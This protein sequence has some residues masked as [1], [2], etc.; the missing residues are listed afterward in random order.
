M[1]LAHA[2]EESRFGL[3]GSAGVFFPTSSV[4]RDKFGSS[5]T[6][7]GISPS[8]ESLPS[9][10]RIFTDI[11]VL[12]ANRSGNR[13]LVIPATIGF[14]KTFGKPADVSR[15]YARVGVGIAYFDYSISHEGRRRSDRNFGAAADAE[16]GVLVG[17]RLRLSARYYFL[18]E[19]DGFNFNGLELA[20]KYTLFRF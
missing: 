3:G 17:G 4:L 15:P 7:I 14:G 9:A 10:A 19:R 8:D 1:P 12:S 18:S 20:V 11:S 16:V 13:F 2:R 6:S 5:V